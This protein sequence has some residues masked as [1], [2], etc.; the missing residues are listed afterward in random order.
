MEFKYNEK[1]PVYS[2]LVDVLRK[3]IKNNYQPNDK[4]LS[5]RES[6]VSMRLVAIRSGKRCLN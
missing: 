5:E 2:Q 1:R 3:E 4:L 6:C